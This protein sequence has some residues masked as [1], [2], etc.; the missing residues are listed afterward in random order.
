MRIVGTAL[1]NRLTA[2]FAHLQTTPVDALAPDL[3]IDTWDQEKTGVSCPDESQLFA[4]DATWPLDDSI[5][6]SAAGGRLIRHQ[7]RD[8]V[9]Y[10]DRQARH[11]VGC[12]VSARQLSVDEQ[13][14]PLGR[15][16]TIWYGDRRVQIVH[17][18][19]V[20]VAGR[21]LLIAGPSGSGKST[22]TLACACAGLDVLADDQLG[23]QDS[24]DGSFTAHSLYGTMRL[25]PDDLARF[26]SLLANAIR[27]GDSCKALILGGTA[28]PDQLRRTV[29]VRAL[30]LPRLSSSNTSRLRP[31]SKAAALHVLATSSLLGPLGAGAPGFARLGRL[32][33]RVSSHW[34][35]LSRD[36]EAVPGLLTDLL[37]EVSTA[38]G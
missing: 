24:A 30:V 17:A 33:E 26:P 25:T 28:F 6:A 37:G 29:P 34:L 22:T 1:A 14:K 35:E 11:I 15:L 13:S 9:A 3:C 2:A 23:L 16:L 38:C 4:A 27:D 18:G 31:A 10:L 32:V 36:I 12:Y 7:H 8:G 21:G 20:A 19:L 5:L